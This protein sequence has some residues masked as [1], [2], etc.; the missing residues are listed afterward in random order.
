MVDLTKALSGLPHSYPFRLIDRVSELEEGKGVGI[1]NVTVNEPF[2][3]GQFKENPIMPGVL[4][5]EAMS[6]MA[7]LVMQYGK[8]KNQKK[9]TYIARINDIKFKIPVF[10]GDRLKITAYTVSSLSSLTQFSVKAFV[11]EHIVA[12]GEIVMAN[13]E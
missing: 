2:F 4:I 1:K 3:E 12:E 5:V 10:P 13:E 9:T 6:Q 7:G 11:G 8:E